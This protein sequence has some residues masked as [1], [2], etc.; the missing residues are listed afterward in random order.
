MR[1]RMILVLVG[2]RCSM[3]NSSSS[4]FYIIHLPSTKP[5]HHHLTSYTYHP[6]KHIINT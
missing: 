1:K 3:T 6:T 2:N 4:L 5:F